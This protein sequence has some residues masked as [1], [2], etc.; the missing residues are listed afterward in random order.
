MP[1]RLEFDVDHH[2]MKDTFVWNLNGVSLCSPGFFLSLNSSFL[3]CFIALRVDPIITPELFAQTIV[4]DYNLAANYHGLIT[5][6]IQ[7]QLSDFKAHHVD[8]ALAG[9]VAANA[10]G[11]AAAILPVVNGTAEGGAN[12]AADGQL[13]L[14][15][16]IPAGRVIK[17]V[18]NDDEVGVLSAQEKVVGKG[19]LD[20]KGTA[21][22]RD[23]KRRLR[24]EGGR[25][26]GE[27]I[28][29]AEDDVDADNEGTG[30]TKK[31][32]LNK[33][34]KKARVNAMDGV[35]V[36]LEENTNGNDMQMETVTQLDKPLAVNEFVLD[37]NTMVEEMR[38]LI[39]VSNH[40]HCLRINNDVLSHFKLDI[41]V[42]SMRLED[43]FEWD[44]ESLNASPER[45]AE[46]YCQDLGL[47]GEF[48]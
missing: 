16:P 18:L 38:I 41:I 24:G 21:W 33:L 32:G 37:E 26:Q 11:G 39:K 8:G 31:A 29:E 2:K 35:K 10:L 9:L 25:Y 19:A 48:K 27:D 6:A 1:I 23:W 47:G 46:I 20:E 34:R 12:S 13:V 43:Q 28:D 22:W 15:A 14:S 30:V 7:D 4:E 36:K 42:G 40:E 44:L 17:A 45:F 3:T 5:K